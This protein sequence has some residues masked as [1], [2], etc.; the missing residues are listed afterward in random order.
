L[1][2]WGGAGP[3]AL[4]HHANGFCAATLDLVAR[5]LTRHFRVIGM[6]ARG[7]GDSSRPTGADAD[8]YQ[9]REFGADLAAVARVLAAEAGGRI[10][11]GLG[12]SF[13]GTSMLLA[14]AQEPDL[15]ERLVLVDP[16]LHAPR[17]A[18]SWDPER[19]ARAGS[20]LERAARRRAVF[21]DRAAARE[22]WRDKELFQ[23][24]DPRAYELYLAEGLGD[25]ADGQVELKCAPE[26]EAAIY[27]AGPT[28]DVWDRVEKLA[29]PTL[30]LWAMHGDF[31]RSVFADYAA[32]MLNARIQDVDAGHLVPMEQPELVIDAVLAFTGRQRSTG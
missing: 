9:W 12:H 25:R 15:F 23:N 29:V 32:R 2:D 5:P 3:L 8:A 21:P 20:L 4:F 24:W 18:A 31:P 28:T 16:V 30:L 19:L 26:T 13:G 22:N 27:A 1:L 10:A 6:E 11:L 17:A 7:H 14:A